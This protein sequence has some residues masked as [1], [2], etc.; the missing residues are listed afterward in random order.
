MTDS[1][2]LGRVFG[3]PIGVNWSIVVV[4][5]AVIGLLSA[6]I[7]PGLYPDA[8]L[9]ARVAFASAGA[10]LFFLS[11]LGHE[12]GHALLARRHDVGVE[13]ITLWLLGGV[14]KLT[15][16]A[17][18][19][20]A[21]L[22]IAVAGPIASFL[23]G[24]GFAGAAIAM[25]RWSDL[26]LP[27]A[28]LAWLAAVNLLLAVSNL[29]PGAPLDGGR[30]LTAL[31]WKKVGNAER[32]RLLSA[33]AGFVLGSTFMA[34]GLVQT[35]WFGQPTGWWT[36]MIGAFIL[37]A[38]RSEIRTSAI[39]HRLSRMQAAELM[40]LHPPSVPDSISIDQALQPGERSA[41][42]VVR[43]GAEPI[44]YVSRSMARDIEEPTRSW[45]T[46]GRIMARID[47]APRAWANET[48]QDILD[49]AGGDVDH[50]TVI[51]E[52]RHGLTI[53]TLSR[54]QLDPLFAPPDF[55]GRDK[56][57][58]LPSKPLAIGQHQTVV[59]AD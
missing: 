27:A 39:R 14:A 41:V 55:W 58:L 45:T 26:T 17:P 3:I 16:Q 51:H 18:T 53:G 59:G 50:V 57:P 25:N 2:R 36:V 23:L 15:R 33:R 4:A 38:A 13:G 21:E 24:L 42:P 11:I 54:D 31:L 35:T 12:L 48:L 5:A 22:Q 43:W 47:E 49:R 29:L 56:L 37:T 20:R 10:L 44:G 28:V 40:R 34:L 46:V 6:R 8:S 1:L 52:P 32:A 9:M 19:P 30:V 7:L